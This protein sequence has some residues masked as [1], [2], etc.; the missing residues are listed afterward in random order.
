MG[1][2]LRLRL[3]CR[4]RVEFFELPG[5]DVVLGRSEDVD[6]RIEHPSIAP[7]HAKV[8]VRR[9][10]L[11]V[12]ELGGVVGVDGERLY[13]PVTVEPGKPVRLGDLAMSAWPRSEASPI[14]RTL[15]GATIGA[16]IDPV[17]S[18]TRRFEAWREGVRSEVTLLEAEVS[19]DERSAWHRWIEQS[20]QGELLPGGGL[21]EPV[22]A[23][24]RLS[25]VL[26]AA[27]AGRVGLSLEVAVVVARR[28]AE[29]LVRLHASAGPHAGLIPAAVQL[30][31]DGRVVL[32]MPGPRPTDPRVHRA[33]CSPARRMNLVPSVADDAYALAAVVRRLSGGA[34]DRAVDP[35]SEVRTRRAFR[36]AGEAL[37]AGTDA[38]GLDPSQAHV[39]R[40]ARLLAPERN[41]VLGFPAERD[42]G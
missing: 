13:A 22:P 28:L 21:L 33:Y 2:Y 14:G 16:E 24:V 23:G 42:H 17:T 6:L 32:R 19:D 30:G 39:A 38:L 27:D 7:K 31:L 41:R 36:E 15:A 34:L 1:L 25:E 4:G 20:G 10:R 40:I 9:D 29:E 11:I 5:P 8:L 35:F 18:C 37:R 3:E 12:T 26:A